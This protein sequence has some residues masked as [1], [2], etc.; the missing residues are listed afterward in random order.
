LA[1]VSK[2][3]LRP[4]DLVFF[5]NFSH[6]GIYIGNGNFVHAPHTGTRVRV[7]SLSNPYRL[8]NYCGA[9]RI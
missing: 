6:V 8:K 4:G 7:E 2:S 9:C 1:S 5:K 3:D